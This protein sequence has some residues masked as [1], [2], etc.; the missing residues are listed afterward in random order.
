[1][2]K[3][4]MLTVWFLLQAENFREMYLHV[5][6]MYLHDIKMYSPQLILKAEVS[7]YIFF[8]S[9]LYGKES[10]FSWNHRYEYPKPESKDI[11]G[12]DYAPHL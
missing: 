5:V 9:K 6:E 1:M 10:L 2:R 3:F 7:T 11:Q 12:L 4:A 8:W